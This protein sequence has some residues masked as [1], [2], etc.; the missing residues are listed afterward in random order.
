MI[1]KVRKTYKYF[2]FVVL[3]ISSPFVFY[4]FSLQLS[5]IANTI[6]TISYLCLLLLT[7]EAFFLNI[8]INGEFLES[9][10]FKVKLSDIIDI[11]N[12]IFST[13]IR[14][15]WKMYY[16]PPMEKI[17]LNHKSPKIRTLKSDNHF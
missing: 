5:T 4:L 12:G 16:L 10:F 14:T 17:N 2:T 13:K 3:L 8:K 15:M 1:Y 9:M 11:E 7:A 6:V